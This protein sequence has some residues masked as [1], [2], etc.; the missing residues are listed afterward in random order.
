MYGETS[1]NELTDF[2]GL[3]YNSTLCVTQLNDAWANYVANNKK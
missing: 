1:Y 3:V 2:R